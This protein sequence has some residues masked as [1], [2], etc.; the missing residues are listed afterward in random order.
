M[1]KLRTLSKMSPVDQILAVEVLLCLTFSWVAVEFVPRRWLLPLYGHRMVESPQRLDKKQVRTVFRIARILAT[2]QRNLPWQSTC[3]MNAVAAK[4]LLTRRHISSTL[5]V[6]FK[7][8]GEGET[9]ELTGHAWLRSGKVPVTGY[10]VGP[11]YRVMTYYGTI[12]T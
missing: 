10:K 5:Y 7:Q 11:G 8:D 2:V 3:L 6:G 12:P 4:L 1:H 9:R